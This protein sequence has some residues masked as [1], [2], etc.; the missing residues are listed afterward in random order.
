[1]NIYK[2]ALKLTEEI[3]EISKYG[4]ND[5]YRIPDIVHSLDSKQWESKKWLVTELEK[6]WEWVGGRI[7]IAGGWYGL[8]AH[9]LYTGKFTRPDFY[10]TSG[11]IDPEASYYGRKLFPS[12]DHDFQFVE[13]DSFADL[14]ECE[15]W[16]TTSGEHVDPDILKKLIKNKPY[17]MLM[18]VQSNDYFSHPSHINCYKTLDEFV[19]S[20]GFQYVWYQGALN[21]GDFN[22]WMVIG[23]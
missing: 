13:E 6:A 5:L 7:Y 12:A 17:E 14:P 3:Y 23:Q 21:L 15:I 10:I 11:D 8:L 4:E 9:L 1:M 16:I 22:R 19:N 20:L 18:V 2:N